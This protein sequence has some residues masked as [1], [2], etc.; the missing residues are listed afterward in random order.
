MGAAGTTN[1]AGTA[2]TGEVTGAAGTA[3]AAGTTSVPNGSVGCG[4]PT[5]AGITVG[6]VTAR[7]V[8][9]AGLDP[10]YLP[11]GMYAA[12]SGTFDFT[13]RPYGVRLPTSY[14]ANQAYPVVFVGGGCGGTAAQFA[15]A[16]SAGSLK[17]PTNLSAIEVTLSMVDGCF[18]D[19]GPGIGNRSDTPE[20]PYF[21]AVL[22]DV[23]AQ[24][25]VDTSKVFLA[26]YASGGWNAQTLACAAGDVVSGVAVWSGGLRA[27]RPPC[28]GPTAAL[29]ILNTGDVGSAMG[30]LDPA[31][32]QY[33]RLGSPGD[34]PSRDELLARNDCIGDAMAPWDPAYPACVTYTGCPITAPVVWC[35]YAAPGQ[36]PTSYQGVSYM[37]GPMW[38]FLG[39]LR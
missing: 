11:G 30:P 35:Q 18:R 20:L 25:C 22:T 2:G 32:P 19:G 33:I 15:A 37:P 23:E 38:K 6:T 8:D 27:M 12:Q 3:G 1:L 16:P 14:I 39:S 36:S 13:H 21:R 4:K 7:I 5:P 26:G 31:D 17:V 24:F 9:V 28:T 34:V 10:V 29:L